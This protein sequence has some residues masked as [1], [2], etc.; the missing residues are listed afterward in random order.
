MGGRNLAFLRTIYSVAFLVSME[1]I[2]MCICDVLNITE[3]ESGNDPY[4][5]YFMFVWSRYYY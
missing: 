5:H 2:Y 1:I 4:S 3:L